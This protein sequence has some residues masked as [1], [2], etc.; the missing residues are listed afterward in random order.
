MTSTAL[1]SSAAKPAVAVLDPPRSG[2]AVDPLGSVAADLARLEA[3]LTDDTG[4]E[5]PVVAELL[6]AVF[7]AGGKRLRPA[8]VFHAAALGTEAG[9]GP[10]RAA[11]PPAGDAVL[12]LAAAV[13]TLHTATLVHDDLVDGAL[14]RRGLPT[15]NARWQTGA[16]VLAGD[17][18]FARAAR[19]A[20]DTGSVGVMRIFA[21]TLGTLTDG[22]LRQLLGRADVPDRAEYARRIY[23]KTASLFEAAAEATG[24][25][26]ALTDDGVAA[27]A[28]YGRAVGM[29]FQV[30]DD[31]LD[32]T[33]D[34]TRL[35][36]PVGSDLRSGQ[37]TLPVLLHLERNP[38]AADGLSDGDGRPNAAVAERLVAAVR[39][40][41]AALDGA[42]AAARAH[43]A[44]ALE[45]LGALPAGPG[46]DGLA[47]VAEY[48][49][50]RDV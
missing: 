18:L 46:R 43:V 15:L 9:P 5:F 44:E 11:P 33:A 2:A 1:P 24:V 31:L 38:G 19:F 48:A 41:D 39:A 20:A 50:A 7:G 28:R 34:E 22:E 10:T 17:W 47:A 37:V 35:G 14:V 4:I 8:V 23:A 30:V 21:R 13:E 25:L 40:D 12:R 45:A 26:L 6:R 49:V 29:A 3:L 42:R 16:T 32:F 27:L 36:K